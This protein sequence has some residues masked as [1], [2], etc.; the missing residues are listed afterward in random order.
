MIAVFRP[1]RAGDTDAVLRCVRTLRA[2]NETRGFCP[3]GKGGGIDNSCPTGK[4]SGGGDS[5]SSGG[6]TDNV[7]QGGSDSAAGSAAKKASKA[8]KAIDSGRVPAGSEMSTPE[9]HFAQAAVNAAQAFEESAQAAAY[10]K[11]ESLSDADYQG[12]AAEASKAGRDAEDHLTSTASQ[13]A[14]AK[15]AKSLA[16]QGLSEKA[17]STIENVMANKAESQGDSVSLAGDEVWVGDISADFAAGFIE[18]IR[19]PRRTKRG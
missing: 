3:T 9:G 12:F 10:K 1:T 15:F 11:W 18:Q 7:A 16:D 14:G 2:V 4:G 5:G 8:A 13:K 6:L 19:K 17:S